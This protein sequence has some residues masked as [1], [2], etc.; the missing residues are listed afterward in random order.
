MNILLTGGTGYIGSHTAVVLAQAGHQIVLLD[1][2]SNS[3][4]SVLA[5]VKALTRSHIAFVHGDVRNQELVHKVLMDHHIDA[6]IH[7][8]GVKAVGESVE[9]PL[10]YYD[11][12]VGG[13]LSL[14]KAMRH[15]RV[16]TLV[17]SS[18]STV[19]GNPQYLPI[20]EDHPTRC[21][22]PYGRSKL[23]VEEMLADLAAADPHWRIALLRYFNPIG[24]HD[25]GL[26]GEDPND[27]PNNLV[28][29]IARVAAGKL[30]CLRV[31]GNDYP[32]PDG[33]GV[34][35]YI[36]VVDLA[37]GHMAALQALARTNQSLHVY[38]LGTG[39]GYSVLEVVRA[40]EQ[41]SGKTIPYHIAPRRAGDIATCY[42][43][44]ARAEAA[45]GW[46]A[47]R[48]L[49]D[50]CASAWKFQASLVLE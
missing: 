13:T 2:L 27:I 4:I 10:R 29:Y 31:F 26:I 41:A 23:H 11:I 30:E 49:Q 24:A 12:N 8:A 6:V 45:L 28:P 44:A 33:T 40:F 22:N 1:N 35:D 50:M 20:D 3:D 16:F 18:S 21:T 42:A 7:F 25:S 9:Q 38:N 15:A 14:L 47:Q 17:F 34:R 36:H 46:K 48:T 39:Q 37:E 5:R 43:Q 19:Y 32:T